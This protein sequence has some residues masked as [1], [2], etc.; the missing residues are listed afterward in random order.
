M[1]SLLRALLESTSEGI[2]VADLAGRI[3][4]YNRKFMALCGIPE[5]VMAPMDLERVLRFLQDQ[6]ADP[7]TFLSEA[8]ALGDRG[9]RRLLGLLNGKDRRVIEAFGRSQRMGNE[10][11][12]RV[13]SFADVTERERGQGPLPETVAVPPEL[14]EA[15]RAGRVVPWYLTEDELVISEKGLAV[16][17]LDPGGLPRDLAGLEA[18]IHPADLD[19]FRRGLEHPRTG[20]FELRMRRGDGSW[21]GTRWNLKRGAEGYRGVFVERPGAGAGQDPV[22]PLD[23]RTPAFNYKVRVLQD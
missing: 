13:F 23:H 17:G 12:G 3:T 5:Y 10:T 7:E 22:Q 4:T 9:E 19:R 1:A 21:I 18:L 14:M 6:F 16:L 15:A 11:V 20:P 2:L 8:R